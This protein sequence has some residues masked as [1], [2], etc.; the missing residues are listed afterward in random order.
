MIAMTIINII[1]LVIL[2]ITSIKI[3]FAINAFE[4]LLARFVE[5]NS[6]YYKSQSHMLTK[7]SELNTE[8]KKISSAVNLL[9]RISIKLN[10]NVE[11]K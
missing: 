5:I 11:K 3:M 9:K 1:V 8:H 7:L 4:E 2:I 10:S 6:N